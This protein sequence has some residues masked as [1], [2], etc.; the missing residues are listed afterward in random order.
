M[1]PLGSSGLPPE[2]GE[3]DEQ[4]PVQAFLMWRSN[5]PDV[6]GKGR[7]FRLSVF[8]FHEAGESPEMDDL[9]EPDAPETRCSK[10]A[11]AV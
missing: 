8:M 1:S 5:R 6:D 7:N 2:I 9:S 11:R 4:R 3:Y 10:S